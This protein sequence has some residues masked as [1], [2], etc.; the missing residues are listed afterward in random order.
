MFSNMKVE[1]IDI[2]KLSDNPEELKTIILNLKNE[3]IK[4]VGELNFDI[5]KLNE[6]IKIYQFKLFGRK[7]ENLPKEEEPGLFNE[8]EIELKDI[9]NETPVEKIRITYERLKK[10]GKR[11]LPPDLP[12]VEKIIDIPED[13]KRSLQEEGKLVKIGEEI[14]EKL[15]II[16]QQVYV[17]KYI[18]Y[19]YSLKKK[20]SKESKIITAE[21][22]AQLIPQG[23][24]TASSSAFVLTNKFVDGLPYYRQE[25]IFERLGID[26]SRKT[27]CNWQIYI[28]YN[29]LVR[30]I[31]LMKRDLKKSYLIGADETT[32]QVI[33]EESKPPG[34]KSYMWIYRGYHKDRIILLYDYESNRKGINR[35]K[36]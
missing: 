13:E 15:E 34:S 2:T 21:L 30:L 4:K 19:K 11:P 24:A 17:L 1:D 5:F 18:R 25:K 29:Y 12:R 28:Y 23:I 20:N 22:P 26:L 33:V 27:M 32:V 6:T 35:K 16:P 9:E 7:S 14:S 8:A 36:I 10:R 31:D 3:H